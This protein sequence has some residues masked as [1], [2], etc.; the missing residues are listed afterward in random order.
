[1]TVELNAEGQP[2]YRFGLDE[3][4]DHLAWSA[5]LAELARQTQAVCF[6][7]LGQRNAASR[8]TIQQFIAATEPTAW[9]VCDI[10]LRRHSTTML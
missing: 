8:A 4:W 5:E 9:R 7:T 1:M 2:T 10:N 3:A 6:G